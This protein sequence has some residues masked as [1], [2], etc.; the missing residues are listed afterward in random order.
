M[1]RITPIPAHWYESVQTTASGGGLEEDRRNLKGNPASGTRYQA[2]CLFLSKF[3]TENRVSVF[4]S[5]GDWSVCPA[6]SSVL[7]SRFGL[8]LKFMKTE[9]SGW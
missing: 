5:Y 3:A 4:G 8:G 1:T 7:V 2:H 6:S 9:I